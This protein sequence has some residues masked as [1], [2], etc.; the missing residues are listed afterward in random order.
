MGTS[1]WGSGPHTPLAS[2]CRRQPFSS[3]VRSGLSSGPASGSRMGIG[4]PQAKRGFHISKPVWSSWAPRCGWLGRV[5]W[6]HLGK[7]SSCANRRAQKT[8]WGSRGGGYGCHA[9]WQPLG[10]AQKQE[11]SG[12]LR[13]GL[14]SC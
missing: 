8:V 9:L 5:R 14:C 3:R 2:G 12:V 4:S 13:G 10:G 11:K 1:S 6:D 7:V